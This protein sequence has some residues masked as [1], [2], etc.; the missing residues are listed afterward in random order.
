MLIKTLQLGELNS[1]CYIVVT[2]A[3]Q[4][5]AID[6]GGS[7]RMVIEYLKMN[8][9]KLSKILLTHGHFDHIAGVEE[10]RQ[11]T[12]AEV[13]IHET[14]SPML[15]S[16]ALSLHSTISI[17]P[18]KPVMKYEIIRDNCIIHDGDCSFRV[19]HTPGHSHGSVCFICDKERVI[20]SGDTLFCCSIGRTDFPGGDAHYM[21]QSLQQLYALDGNYK[22]YPGHNEFTDLEYERRNNPYMKPFRG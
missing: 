17:M 7:P 6:V 19:L 2:G 21:M 4:C 12:G 5:I 1:N 13:F 8:R 15:E 18:F 22:V 20:F 14:D 9:L 10:V 3:N 11:A 16:S